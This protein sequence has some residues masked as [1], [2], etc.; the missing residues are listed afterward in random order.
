[1][2]P[3]RLHNPVIIG[4]SV[5]ALCQSVLLAWAFGGIGGETREWLQT[6]ADLS[7]IRVEGMDGHPMPLPGEGLR[8]VLVFHSECG[9][10]AAVA[11]AWKSWLQEDGKAW[12][13]LSV[14]AEPVETGRDFASRNGW[15]VEVA[16]VETDFRANTGR[17]LTGRTPWVFMVDQD[18]ILV[19]EGHG[20]RLREIAAAAGQA[21]GGAKAR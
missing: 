12:D 3:S 2:G 18:G 10:C 20:R 13:V 5:I 6:G 21:P 14:T 4:L 7:G 17:S 15:A 16:T 11:P 8:I 9:H 1:M 19:A